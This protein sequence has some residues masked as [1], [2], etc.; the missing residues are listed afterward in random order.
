MQ[1]QILRANKN[2]AYLSIKRTLYISLCIYFTLFLTKQGILIEHNFVLCI[3]NR[4]SSVYH[5][6]TICN[7]LMCVFK[8]D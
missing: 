8:D 3:Q 4:F 7:C 6:T 1:L 5:A 2:Y